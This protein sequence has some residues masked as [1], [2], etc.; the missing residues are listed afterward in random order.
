[1]L[2]YSS[3]P[4]SLI[5]SSLH[6]EFQ[7]RNCHDRQYPNHFLRCRKHPALS[8]IS[9]SVDELKQEV[10]ASSSVCSVIADNTV[11]LIRLIQQ[12][13]EFRKVENGKLRLKVSHGNVSMFLKKSVSAFAPLVKKQKLSIQFDLS[14]EYSGYFDV[15]KL[16]KVVYNLLSNAAKYTPEGG[17]IVVSQAHDEEKRTFKLSVNNPGEL[18]PKEKLDHMFERFYEGEYRKFH[19][20]G[21]GIGLSL[22][23]DLVLLHHGTIQVFSDKEE[24]NTFVVEIPIGREAF[25]EDE[26]DENTENVDYAVLS[27]DEMENVSEIDMLEEK[28]AASTILLVEDNE[29]LLALMVRLL[30]GKYHILKAANGTEALEILAKQEV[31]LIVSDVMMPEMDGMELCRR[32]K[33]QFETCHIPLILLTAK[34]SDEDHVEGYE[35]GA[36]GYICKPL[37]LSVLF[38]KIDNLLK[39]RK[40]M[41]VDFR[42]QLVFEA[43]ELNYTSM[44]EAFIRKAVDCVNA[45]LSDCDFEHAQFMAEMGMARTTLADKLKLLTGLTPSAFISNVRLQAACRLIDEKKKIR[46]ADLAYAVGFNDPKYF[47]SCFKKKFGLSPTEYMMKYDG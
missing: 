36:D 5:D 19:T 21:T 47:S 22:T 31:D 39:R 1:M 33:T 41:G 3:L 30:H 14:E 12:I 42:K 17:T 34:T 7:R 24:G 38:A 32:V 23:K 10:P 20:I 26:V 45:H 43:K 11:R 15:D 44:D 35:S 27:A 46:I 18:I 13:L 8:I 40:R 9:A 37:R 16:D 6:N 28:P 29:E 2:N 4:I 25:A